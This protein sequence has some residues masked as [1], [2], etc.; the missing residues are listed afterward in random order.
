[1]PSHSSLAHMPTYI[2]WCRLIV[3]RQR[4]LITTNKTSSTTNAVNPAFRSGQRAPAMR[5]YERKP[6]SPNR[7]RRLTWKLIN[8]PAPARAGET[9]IDRIVGFAH[10]SRHENGGVGRGISFE[11]AASFR[12]RRLIL[13][14]LCAPPPKGR[15]RRW[16]VDSTSNTSHAHPLP[17]FFLLQGTR[18]LTRRW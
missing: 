2:I 6:N 17:R 13:D 15:N 5:T 8:R 16:R 3:R 10:V 12:R 18:P 4:A 9:K 11:F 1:M 7:A 14:G